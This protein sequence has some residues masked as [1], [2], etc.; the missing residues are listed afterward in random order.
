MG[1]GATTVTADL[2]YPKFST[3]SAGTEDA[4]VSPDPTAAAGNSINSDGTG[5]AET[6]DIRATDISSDSLEIGKKEADKAGGDKNTFGSYDTLGTYEI[7]TTAADEAEEA[8]EDLSID[9][10]EAEKEILG[11]ELETLNADEIDSTTKVVDTQKF[12][13]LSTEEEEPS[14]L[15][16]EPAVS[17][18]VVIPQKPTVPS[19]PP[20]DYIACG[21]CKSRIPPFAIYCTFCG[22]HQKSM[23][24]RTP[25]QPREE[26]ELL[27]KAI[28]IMP[29]LFFLG[30]LGSII[31]VILGATF[32]V[33]KTFL[34]ELTSHLPLMLS[35][36]KGGLWGG[37]LFGAIGGIGGFF[38]LAIISVILSCVFNLLAS[39]IGGIR[40]KVKR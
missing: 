17:E 5:N 23:K 12:E 21:V 18:T 20:Q 27:V 24:L 6:V 36:L 19:A 31:G 10:D 11:A 22:A 37:L 34:P 4:E 1:T 7:D 35:E 38:L 26:S 16:T 13:Y 25:V 14:E 40:F 30:G 8:Y 28:K 2:T 32:G 33:V 3:D 29:F 15:T 39:T 9:K